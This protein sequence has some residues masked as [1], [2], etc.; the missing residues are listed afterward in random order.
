[1]K[2][3]IALILVLTLCTLAFAACGGDDK[4][5]TP[6]NNQGNT[7]VETPDNNQGNNNGNNDNNDDNGNNGG[8]VA[9]EPTYYLALVTDGG[10]G[11]ISKSKVTNITLAIVFDAEGKIVAAQFDSVEA[12]VKVTNGEITT[13]DRLETKVEQGDNYAASRPMPAGSWDAQS[14]AFEA[15]LVGKTAAEVAALDVTTEG[16]VA[17]CTMASSM[18]VFQ[19]LVAKAFAYERKVEFTTAEEITLGLA[20]NAKLSGDVEDGATVS[21]DF[22][23]VVVANN[24]VLAAM[25]DSAEA[26][27]AF[28]YDEAEE[29]YTT[30]VTYKGSKNDQGDAYDAYSPMPS[31]RWYAQA[32]AFANTAVGK[33]VA[34]L[35][36]LSTDKIEGSC[37]VYTGGYKAAIVLAAANTV[38]ETVT[39]K[40]YYLVVVTDGGFGTISKNKVTNITLALVIDSE[41]KIVAAQFDSV[42]ASV[43]VTDGE[44]TTSSRLETKVEQGDNYAAS[45]PMPAGSWDA[46]SA[47]FEAFLV[48]KTAAEVAALDVTTEGLVAG[49][50]M[51]SSMP[52]FQQLVAKAFAYERKVEFTTAE[53][54]T[55]GLAIN[56]KLSGDVEDGAT[57]SADF[58]AVVVANNV[59][60]AAMLDSAEAKFAFEYD[61]AEETYTTTV[62][63]K[64]SKNDQGDAYDAYSPMPSGRWYAQAQ[65]FA[66]TA[67]G[68]T[69]AELENLSTDKIEGSCSIYTGG[70]KAVIVLA[71]GYAN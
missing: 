53:E 42:E 34:E 58:A 67:V 18:P 13:S 61:E 26:K 50:T 15:F 12:S 54:I 35:A 47:A 23:A 11:T 63:Y 20:I 39:E 1:M 5:E 40:T 7:N 64:G 46:Q 16:L 9:T 55:L 57:V 2:K 70:Y 25:L 56:A 32:Q 21:A 37:S 30:T 38:T 17:G 33:T 14:A 3:I 22:A 27:F 59:V 36:N 43:K 29:T 41:G 31:G 62:T 24:V 10:F 28:E 60:L 51:A 52:V 44:I 71:A 49:C 68:K 45:R 6:D 8:S 19:Q 48:G 4:D 65:A 66:N 69:V